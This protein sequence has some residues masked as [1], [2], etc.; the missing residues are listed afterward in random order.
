LWKWV[1]GGGGG[2]GGGGG[3]GGGESRLAA[4]RIRSVTLYV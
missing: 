3:G 1:G 4:G 2:W